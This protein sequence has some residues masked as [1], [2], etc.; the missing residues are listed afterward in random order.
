VIENKAVTGIW[1]LGRKK[2]DT[3]HPLFFVSAA[4]K[5][6][7]FFVSLLFATLAGWSVGVAAKG[8]AG[9]IM[10]LTQKDDILPL[11]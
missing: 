7:T 10:H 1:W 4:S 3:P 2:I 8:F 6:V 5:G 11:P 9:A